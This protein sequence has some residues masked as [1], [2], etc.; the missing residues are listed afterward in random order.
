MGTMRWCQRKNRRAE[1]LCHFEAG[2]LGW[3]GCR[4]KLVIE[5][6]QSLYRRNVVTVCGFEYLRPMSIVVCSAEARAQPVAPRA[7]KIVPLAHII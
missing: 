4:D 1:V 6:R 2:R 5:F 3:K 7:H